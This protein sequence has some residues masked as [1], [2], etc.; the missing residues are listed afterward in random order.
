MD[1]TL[2]AVANNRRQNRQS[3]GLS[4]DARPPLVVV[5]ASA[6]ERAAHEQ[7]LE[8]LDKS[9]EGRCVWRRINTG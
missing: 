8:A 4:R 9:S 7:Y 2:D 1:L 5:R 3:A 6:E